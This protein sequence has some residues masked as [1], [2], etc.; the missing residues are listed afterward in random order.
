MAHSVF[1]AACAG[2]RPAECA[3]SCRCR[4][5][6]QHYQ[7]LYDMPDLNSFYLTL[8][9]QGHRTES[10]KC[11][12]E[13][14][15]LFRHM[16]ACILILNGLETRATRVAGYTD[17]ISSCSKEIV[18]PPHNSIEADRGSCAWLARVREPNTSASNPRTRG[19]RRCA[20]EQ[21]A[22]GVTYFLSYFRRPQP[23]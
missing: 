8:N 9:N 11:E 13:G 5:L 19:R 20:G 6:A 4:A 15:V 14:S 10:E 23:C 7:T 18:V 17:S 12:S 2:I 21:N 22:S 16:F 1:E 3:G